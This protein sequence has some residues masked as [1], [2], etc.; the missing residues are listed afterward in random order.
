MH[1]VSRIPFPD[2]VALMQIS[3]AHVYWTYPFV[4]SWSLLQAMSVGAPVIASRTPPVCEVIEEGVNGALVDFFDVEGLARRVVEVL[5]TP[6]AFVGMGEAA[7]RT[8]RERF[9]LKRICLPGWRALI[10]AG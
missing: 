4:L 3:S 6:S 10:G 2:F 1:F 5:E 7:R 9:D 8:V